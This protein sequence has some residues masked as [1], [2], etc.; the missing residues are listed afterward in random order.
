[1]PSR[2]IA[3]GIIPMPA[4]SG[5]STYAPNMPP[6]QL[7]FIAKGIIPL[8]AGHG[9]STPSPTSYPNPQTLLPQSL[10]AE[11]DI[12]QGSELAFRNTDSPLASCGDSTPSARSQARSALIAQDIM[13]SSS[14]SGTVANAAPMPQTGSRFIAKGI[15]PM[16]GPPAPPPGLAGSAGVDLTPQILRILS[17][18]IAKSIMPIPAPTPASP[19]SPTAFAD[20]FAATLELQRRSKF[21]AKG[22]IPIPVHQQ[23]PARLISSYPEPLTLLPNDLLLELNVE[24]GSDLA[25]AYNRRTVSGRSSVQD[26]AARLIFG[27]ANNSVMTAPSALPSSSAISVTSSLGSD[28]MSIS[29]GPSPEPR[30]PCASASPTANTLAII[31]VH[32]HPWTGEPIITPSRTGVRKAGSPYMFRKCGSGAC[33]ICGTWWRERMVGISHE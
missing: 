30:S 31:T 1:M 9:P 26:L 29:T 33:T 6:T 11:L 4:G 16:S 19:S 20:G 18:S 5:N 2:F 7:R 3:K 23:E 25:N 22:V 15:I 32:R 27:L 21:I 28:D 12:E 17:G 10:G 14:E 13:P 24:A 8:P